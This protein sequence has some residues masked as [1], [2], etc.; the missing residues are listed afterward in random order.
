MTDYALL[1]EMQRATE[2]LAESSVRVTPE[3]IV[4]LAGNCPADYPVIHAILQRR[5][6]EVWN[7]FIADLERLMEQLTG[8]TMPR[9][10]IASAI[11]SSEAILEAIYRTTQERAAIDL[12][13]AVA[14]LRS[15]GHSTAQ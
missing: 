13:D 10:A 3:A 6:A 4:E 7:E 11:E 15:Q 12:V 2:T 1:S 8:T 9:Y 14:D 5:T